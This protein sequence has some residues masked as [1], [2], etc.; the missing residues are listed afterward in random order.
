MK[1]SIIYEAQMVDTSREAEARCFEE[2]VE[3][4]MLAEEV[5]FDT[6]WAVEH[7]ALTQYAHMSAPETF[8][9]YIAGRTKTIGIGHGVVCLPPAMNHPVKVAERIATLDILSGGRVHFG[10]GKG[11]T[12]QEAGTFGYDL[13]DLQPMIDESMYLIPKIM[14]EDE[15]E[16]D[17]EYIKIPRRPI[18]PKP[19]QNPH[20]PLYYACTREATLTLAGS[21]GIGALVLGFSGP[22]EIAKKNKIYREAFANRKAEDQV[23]YRPTEHLAAFCA[24][25]VLDDRDEARRIGLRGQRFFAEA[26]AH[27]YQ[28]GPKPTPVDLSAEEQEAA[29]G[30]SKEAIVTY[31]SE[32]K[33]EIGD[34]HTSNYAVAQDAYGTPEDCIRYVTRLREAGADEVLFLFQMGGIPHETIMETIRNIGEKVIPHFREANQEAIAAE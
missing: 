2:I 11:G 27:W 15:I 29:L 34:E 33:I 5:G 31:L 4:V 14:V 9:A 12:Q 10:M 16:H 13:A 7:T 30:Q 24:A 6:I 25:C 22:E 21:R 19:V 23:G 1:F 3:Q 20:P 18:H 17:G 32:E 8:L 28:G 26:I